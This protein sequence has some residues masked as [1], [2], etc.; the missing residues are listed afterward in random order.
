MWRKKSREVSFGLVFHCLW[1]SFPWLFSCYRVKVTKGLGPPLC[2][3]LIHVFERYDAMLLVIKIV[4]KA[5][6]MLFVY[7]MCCTAYTF[8]DESIL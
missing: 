5:S 8:S 4:K 6:S 1:H 7:L 3:V 2:V